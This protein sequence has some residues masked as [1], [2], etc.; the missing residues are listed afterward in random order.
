MHTLALD[1]RGQEECGGG[2]FF[3]ESLDQLQPLAGESMCLID[4]DEVPRHS[5]HKLPDVGTLRKID[6]QRVDSFRPIIG[7]VSELLSK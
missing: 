6:T 4:H 2:L 7:R 5:A 1:G 3:D